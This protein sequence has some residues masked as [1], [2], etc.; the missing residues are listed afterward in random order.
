MGQFECNAT[1]KGC[2]LIA[3]GGA[4]TPTEHGSDLIL[5]LKGSEFRVFAF[6]AVLKYGD[7]DSLSQNDAA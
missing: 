7:S 4:A 6:V 3:V 1:L 2:E 5:T